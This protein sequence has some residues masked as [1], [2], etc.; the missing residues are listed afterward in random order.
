[1]ALIFTIGYEGT[2]VD[3]FVE[4]LK[5]VGVDCIADVRAVPISRKKGF[6]KKALSARLEQEGIRYLHFVGLGNPKSGRDAARAGHYLKFKKIFESHMM[7]DDARSSLKEVVAVAYARATCL[8]C[9]ERNPKV[10]HRSIIAGEMSECGFEVFDLFGDDA[11][12]YVRNASRVPRYHPR[13]GAA[14]A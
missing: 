14:A 6:S 9:F 11:A 3:T 4:T 7:T 2:D 10:C 5:A 8:L 1:M 13:E 12:R